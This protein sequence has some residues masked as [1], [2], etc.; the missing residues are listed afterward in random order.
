MAL[1]TASSSSISMSAE[2]ARALHNRGSH[3]PAQA[4]SAG[5]PSFWVR[6][7]VAF[8]VLMGD[9]AVR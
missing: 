2:P 7:E 5:H 4:N 3:S 6:F 8:P 9:F 1:L